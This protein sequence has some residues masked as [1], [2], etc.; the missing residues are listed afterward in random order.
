MSKNPNSYRP[1]PGGAAWSSEPGFSL[2]YLAWGERRYGRTPLPAQRVEDWIYVAPRSGAPT[3]RVDG[4]AWVVT[5]GH[6]LVLAP[7]CVTSY[8]DAPGARCVIQTWVWADAPRLK[9]L[10]PPEGQGCLRV[11]LSRSEFRE[12]TAI[13]DA[14]RSEVQHPDAFTSEALLALRLRLDLLLAR[15][16][17]G[18]ANSP[19]P[20]AQRFALAHRWLK[21]HLAEHNPSE[22]LCDYLQISPATLRRLFA[23]HLGRG[24]REEALGLR[25]AEARRLITVEG[26]SVKAAAYHLGYRHPND[27]SRA[28]KAESSSV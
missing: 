14:C 15:G 6:C 4:R 23:R 26:W 1:P 17:P 5:S 7:G 3:V 24:V 21:E 20:S 9:A 28:M 8:E 19:A 10:H 11:E 13:H 12:L 27:L 22:G 16:S 25:M 18:R 2:L